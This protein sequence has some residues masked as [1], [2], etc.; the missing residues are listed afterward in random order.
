MQVF[1]LSSAAS[2]MN[3]P[4]T[5]LDMEAGI[6]PRHFKNE[7]IS[8]FSS[9]RLCN[10]SEPQLGNEQLECYSYFISSCSRWNIVI[11]L[12]CHRFCVS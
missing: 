3:E 4:E 11:V 1:G 10:S 6:D 12:G 8:V 9:N 5:R 2:Q 7:Y